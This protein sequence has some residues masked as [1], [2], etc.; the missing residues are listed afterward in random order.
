MIEPTLLYDNDNCFS[1]GFIYVASRDRFYYELALISCQTLKDYWPNVSVTLFTHETFIDDRVK[2]F[3]KVYTNIP[4]HKRA[5]MWCMARTPYERTIYN[6]CD[7]IINHRDV[8]KMHAFL[9]ACDM[10]FCK[11]IDYTVANFKW[12][13]IDK[14]QKIEPKYHGALCGYKKSALTIDFMQ[15]WFD[16]YI[17]Q[18]TNPWEYEEKHYQEWQQFDMFTLWRMTDGSFQEFDRFNELDI[19]L[20]PRRFNSSGQDLPADLDGPKV[21]IQIDSE[22]WKRIPTA[23]NKIKETLYDEKHTI[24]QS[25]FDKNAIRYD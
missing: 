22:T 1:D 21:I 15:T 25:A 14:A 3:D 8:K 24:K 12:A 20:V 10:F 6:D 13:Y 18:I 16:E 5:K 11:N 9:D 4:I 19:K 2:I 17:K 7:S 23:W